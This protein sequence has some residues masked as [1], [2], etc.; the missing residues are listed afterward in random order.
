MNSIK[1]S[2]TVQFDIVGPDSTTEVTAEADTG[3]TIT[4]F[5]EYMF[6]QLNWLELEET[7]MIIQAYDG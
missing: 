2:N 5:K 4:V 3:A 1:P 6:Q 7:S